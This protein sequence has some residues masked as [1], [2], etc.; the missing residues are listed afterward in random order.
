MRGGGGEKDIPE[1]WA[2]VERERERHCR[3]NLLALAGLSG[4]HVPQELDRQ[5]GRE[6]NKLDR[7]HRIPLQSAL[8]A[9]VLNID[10]YVH[11]VTRRREGR[12]V[13][14]CVCTH[15]FKWLLRWLGCAQRQLQHKKSYDTTAEI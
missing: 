8:L 9:E 14:V 4:V 5:H 15:T 3:R 11:G 6:A 13:G 10:T 2:H 12:G 1:S 7:A